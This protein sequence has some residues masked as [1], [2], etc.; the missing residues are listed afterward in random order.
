MAHFSLFNDSLQFGLY[1]DWRFRGDFTLLKVE[2]DWS[3]D[4]GFIDLYLGLFGINLSISLCFEPSGE[5]KKRLEEE[6]EWSEGRQK[7]N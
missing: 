7:K 5:V 2:A 3:K 1:Q 6:P 4:Y